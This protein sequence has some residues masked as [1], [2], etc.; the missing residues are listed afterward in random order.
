[1]K[2][3]LLIICLQ[4]MGSAMLYAQ[5]VK[6]TENIE[7][8]WMG[9]FNQSRLSNKWGVWTDLH[10]RTKE[11][12][13]NHFSQA[14]IRLG[15]TYYINNNTKFTAG[16][17][18]VF[19][20][21]GDNHRQI[22]QPEHRPWQ[23]LQWH[24]TFTKT[25]LMQWIRLEERYR[26][27]I[28][29]DSTLAEGYNFNWRLRYNIWYEVPLVKNGVVPK[30]LSFIVNDELHINFGKEIVYNY[31]DQNRFFLGLKYQFSKSSNIQAG[32]MNLFQQLAA[33]NKYKNINAVRVFFF[34]NFDLRK[35][36]GTK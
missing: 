34:Q 14:I 25:R 20:F 15:L 22:T 29:N 23:Q 7:Q 17:A 30:S 24:T 11:D 10:L 31:F 3:T 27:K 18:R 32:Y 36:T 12:F 13:T 5:T 28:L 19:L 16:Y 4:A 6:S 9:Y 8:A 33:G 2:R 35:K 26:R 21:P 1:M